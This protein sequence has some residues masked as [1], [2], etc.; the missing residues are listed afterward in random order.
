MR[1]AEIVQLC[2]QTSVMAAIL[3]TAISQLSHLQLSPAPYNARH[4]M[5]NCNLYP[6]VTNSA[7]PTNTNHTVPWT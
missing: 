6:I 4:P 2:A 5:L 7:F 3:Q 1:D